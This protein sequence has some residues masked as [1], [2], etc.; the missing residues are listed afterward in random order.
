MHPLKRRHVLLLLEERVE[1]LP[2][3]DLS[4]FVWEA[5][6]GVAR[7]LQGSVWRWWVGGWVGG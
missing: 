5:D 1:A 4:S 2:V 7:K 3:V 6:D